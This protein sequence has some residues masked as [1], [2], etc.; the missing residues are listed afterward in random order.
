MHAV[1]KYVCSNTKPRTFDS[2]FLSNVTCCNWNCYNLR[3]FLESRA[4]NIWLVLT[5]LQIQGWEEKIKFIKLSIFN[6][7]FLFKNKHLYRTQCCYRIV[8]SHQVYLCTLQPNPKISYVT[9]IFSKWGVKKH[10]YF[11]I[12]YSH[13]SHSTIN[14]PYLKSFMWIFFNV[15]YVFFFV[16]KFESKYVNY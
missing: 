5:W 11:L 4:T 10:L 16:S 14:C 13:D 2:P 3:Q 8:F 7:W 9:L 12:Y 1:E 15:H 6:D